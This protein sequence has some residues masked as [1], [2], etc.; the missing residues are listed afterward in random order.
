MVLICKVWGQTNLVP[1]PSFEMYDTCPNQAS[2]LI[3]ATPWFP[4]STGTPDYFNSCASVINGV[5]VP[6]TF[7]G[8]CNAH[9][10]IAMSG[11]LFYD[12]VSASNLI[13]REYLAVRL[14]SPL[15]NNQKYYVT[16]FVRL[17]DSARYATDDI[18]VLFKGD[19]IHKTTYDTINATPQINNPTSNFITNKASWT[20]LKGSF[21]SNGTEKYMYIGSFNPQK[22]NDTLFVSGGGR[23]QYN[24]FPY[25]F[26]D[27]ICVST[28]SLYSENWTSNINQMEESGLELFPNPVKSYLFLKNYGFNAKFKVYNMYGEEMIV[29]QA[30]GYIDFSTVESNIYFLK[31]ITEGNK[32][33]TYKIL[34][35]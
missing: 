29:R 19:S 35:Q 33:Y 23:K 11:E 18:S 20:K 8:T 13:Y 9:S 26:F 12:N 4:P 21:I 5:N 34:K 16:Y 2:Q 24:N 22:T 6:V 1:N 30:N 31:Y 28:D 32:S 3:Y 15:V 14:I 17:A 10:G 25:Y 27:D 7:I